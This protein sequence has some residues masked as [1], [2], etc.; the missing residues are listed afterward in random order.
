MGD[1]SRDFGRL[2]E[3]MGD[4]MRDCW[5]LWESVSATARDDGRWYGVVYTGDCR[6]LSE[7]EWEGM[8]EYERVWTSM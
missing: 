6:R 7:I 8:G 1:G 4:R 3:I 2:W 5:R